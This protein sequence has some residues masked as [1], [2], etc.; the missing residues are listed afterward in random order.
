M[1]ISGEFLNRHFGIK[2][3]TLAQRKETNE[4]FKRNTPSPIADTRCAAGLHVQDNAAPEGET[5]SGGARVDGVEYKAESIRPDGGYQAAQDGSGPVLRPDTK[6]AV[7][8]TEGVLRGGDEVEYR[9]EMSYGHVVSAAAKDLRFDRPKA[10]WD[11]KVIDGPACTER[12]MAIK[13]AKMIAPPKGSVWLRL[14]IYF[15]GKVIIR[16]FTVAKETSGNKK[17]MAELAE[18]YRERIRR[19][20]GF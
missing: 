3:P 8:R 5:G 20:E 12:N 10:K 2:S 19:R 14:R 15:R 7:E 9:E 4:Y 18:R 17:A 16:L 11:F 1:D 6:G 13:D